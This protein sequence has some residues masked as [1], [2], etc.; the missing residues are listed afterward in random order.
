[1]VTGKQ[2]HVAFPQLADNPIRGLV[3]LMSA[4]MAQPLDHGSAHFEASNLEFTSI[5]IG[6]RTVNLIPGEARARFN[7]RYNDLHTLE[8]LKRLIE[9]RCTDA[10]AN[11]LRWR[12]EYEPSNSQAFLTQPGPFADLVAGP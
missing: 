6:N 1:V 11:G 12:I 5:D 3:A 8:S 10:A 2:G 7:I 9:T 4:L